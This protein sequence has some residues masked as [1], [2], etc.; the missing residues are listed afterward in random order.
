MESSDLAS[1]CFLIEHST[2]RYFKSLSVWLLEYSLWFLTPAW[3]L[4][5]C[6]LR[7]LA[8]TEKFSY[9]LSE[10]TIAGG[11][12]IMDR[13]VWWLT[14]EKKCKEGRL[15][16][17]TNVKLCYMFSSPLGD[18]LQAFYL[19]CAHLL[20]KMMTWRWKWCGP[21]LQGIEYNE[22]T[23]KLTKDADKVM[24]EERVVN[25][26]GWRWRRRKEFTERVGIYQA[27]EKI[28]QPR[29]KKLHAQNKFQ[30]DW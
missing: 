24:A 3:N 6:K 22:E 21:C 25:L 27:N 20:F 18:N 30:R 4:Q 7:L 2:S 13:W 17:N 28:R 23:Y 16:Q 8:L 1:T 10:A 19:L 5:T 26:L 9:C 29:Q 15:K 14:K 11:S 12:L